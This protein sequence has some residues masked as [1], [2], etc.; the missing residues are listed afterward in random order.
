MLTKVVPTLVV[1]LL[2]LAP[3][4]H[5]QDGGADAGAGGTGSTGGAAYEPG[6][7]SLTA[8]PGA[9]LGRDVRFT[10]RAEPGDVVAIERLDDED[11]WVEVATATAGSD[12]AY[13]TSWGAD[14]VGVHRFRGTLETGARA[15]TATAP[16]ELELTVF[17]PAVA[18]WYGP[19]FYGRRTACGQ[20]MSKRLQGVAHRTLPCGTKVRL[21]YRGRT[22]TVRVVDRGPFRRG[23]TWDLTRATARAL[24]MDAP[25][26]IGAYVASM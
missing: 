15:R 4:A 22:A 19:G 2:A 7:F 23:R 8:R 20:R 13:H 17:R 12:G 10:G 11:G 21:Y 1:A 9:L 5:A 6:G 3:A 18:S 16:T 26:R 25:A 14:S 24:R